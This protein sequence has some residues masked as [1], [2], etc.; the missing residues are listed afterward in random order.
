MLHGNGFSCLWIAL[1]C[2]RRCPLLENTLKTHWEH[3]SLGLLSLCTL[4]TWSLRV[5]LSKSALEQMGHVSP[6]I[7]SVQCLRPWAQ[8]WQGLDFP[9]A[10]CSCSCKVERLEKA[11]LQSEHI[12]IKQP[13]SFDASSSLPCV[14]SCAHNSGTLMAGALLFSSR[15]YIARVLSDVMW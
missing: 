8:A 12:K 3:S 9:C 11:R 5:C 2:L 7:D 6:F 4:L 15:G 13:H 10:V 14:Q 1:M